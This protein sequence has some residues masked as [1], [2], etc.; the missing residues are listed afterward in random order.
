MSGLSSSMKYAEIPFAN[1]LTRHATIY[2]TFRKDVVL[3]YDI[4]RYKLAN[5]QTLCVSCVH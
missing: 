3:E 1:A 2:L 4:D 5:S